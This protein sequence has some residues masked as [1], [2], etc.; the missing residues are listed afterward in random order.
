MLH[1]DVECRISRVVTTMTFVVSLYLQDL[2]KVVLSFHIL[3]VLLVLFSPFLSSLNAEKSIF[4][5]VQY[6]SVHLRV[7]RYPRVL[8]KVV[9]L[10]KSSFKAAFRA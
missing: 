6:K 3:Q 4:S 2:N 7:L 5:L 10:P 8:Q 9:S 1:P